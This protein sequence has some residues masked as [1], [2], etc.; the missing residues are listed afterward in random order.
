MARILSINPG[1]TST[2]IGI[3]DDNNKLLEKVIRHSTEELTRYAKVA[4][5]FEFR[6]SEI[7]QAL[8]ENEIT[9]ESLTAIACRGGLTKPISGGTY[10]VT[11]EVC[12]MQRTSPYQH[13]ANLA[14]I[15]GKDMADQL[16]IKAYFVDSPMTYEM[17]DLAEFSGHKEIKRLGRFH[18]LNQKAIARK[19]ASD[20]GKRYEDINIIVCHMGGGI[21]VGAHSKGLV[22][23]V[24]DAVDEGP[25]TPERTGSLP[26]R[27]LVDLCFSGKYNHGEMKKFIQ[28][29]GGLNSYLDM[30]DAKAIEEKSHNDEEARLVLEAMAYQ[31]SK[32][33]T[34]LGA[35]LKGDIDGIILT[36]GIAYSKRITNWIRERVSHLAEVHVYPGEKELEALAEGVLRVLNNE[37][38]PKLLDF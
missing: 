14:C 3:F 25:F 19:Y 17:Q 9:L 38:E 31:I 12:E 22:I 11:D 15:I 1:S 13:P 36:G 27:L 33:I 34:S 23:D 6:R 28:G 2:K 18:A 26:P 32:E 37:E 8:D 7:T 21:S 10:L 24:N 29:N 4:D 16:G 30:N 20:C 5:Q 35:V